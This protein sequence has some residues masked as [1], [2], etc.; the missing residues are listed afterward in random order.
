MQIPETM[1]QQV[2]SEMAKFESWYSARR[3]PPFGLFD[4]SYGAHVRAAAPHRVRDF[5]KEAD[6]AGAYGR[7][8]Y[9]SCDRETAELAFNGFTKR[10]YAE[11]MIRIVL[12]ADSQRVLDRWADHDFRALAAPK[13]WGDPI[14]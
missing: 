2:I 11:Q 8:V 1:I 6:A 12:A 14:S 5:T 3:Q 13:E 7:E 4:Y 9:R 10:Y